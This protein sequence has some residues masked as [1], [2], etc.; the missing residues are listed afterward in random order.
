MKEL[1][2]VHLVR[3]YHS[4]E[5]FRCFLESY[6]QNPG[7]I[8]H[9]LLIVFKGFGQPQDIA[10]YHELLAPFRYTTIDVSDEG[11][12]ITAY[13]AAVNR[14]SEHYRYFCF[15]NSYY[16]MMGL[17][18][19]VKPV[20]RRGMG[21]NMLRPLYSGLANTKAEKLGITLPRWKE[22]LGKYLKTKHGTE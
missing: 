5:P 4:I 11:F 13:F 10:E 19:E 2:V 20:D 15:L 6:R 21:G 22:S 8:E 7:V 14:Y 3:A 9:D 12:D 1:C 18:T 17:K 16:E